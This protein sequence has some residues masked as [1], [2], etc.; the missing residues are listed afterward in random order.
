MS[1][2]AGI[3]RFNN[4]SALEEGLNMMK[5]IEQ[6]PSDHTGFWHDRSLFVGCAATWITP[7]SVGQPAPFYDEEHGLVITADA[8]I[9]NR[10]ELFNRLQIEPGKRKWMSDSELIGLAYLKW[11]T[12]AADY[13]IGDYAF[14]VWDS[15][16]Q[17]LFGARDP[18]GNRTLYYDHDEHKFS[19][20][21]AITP[22]LPAIGRF[23][24]LNQSWLAGFLAIPDLY[25][26]TDPASTPYQNISQLPSG[27]SFTVRNGRSHV[28]H[29]CSLLPSET[30]KFAS[31]GEVLEA[32]Q[33]VFQE[34]TA[35]RLRTFH[36][37]GATL[38][39][40]LDSSTVVSQAAG[41]LR[42]DN[43]ILYTYSYVPPDDFRDWTGKSRMAD[44]RP[45]IKATV[46]HVG[47]IKD[48]YLSLPGSSPL[49][50]IDSLLET[51]EVPYKNFENSFWIK[52]IYEHAA[53]DKI[54]ILLTGARGNYTISW[55]SV[56]DY[57]THLLRSF[58]YVRFY[59]ASKQFGKQMGIRRARLLPLLARNAYPFL[60][61]RSAPEPEFPSMI[62]AGFAH[63][64]GIMGKLQEERSGNSPAPGHMMLDRQ[65]YFGNPGIVGF[66]GGFGAKLSARYGLWERDVTADLRVIRFCLSLPVEQYIQQGV[67]RA[68]VRR[69]TAHL[70]PDQVRM[71]QHTRG[72]Q[73][74]DW[75]HRMLPTWG[76]FRRELEELS[77]DSMAAYFL[78][79]AK[80][81]EVLGRWPAAPEPERA[82]DLELR[83]LMRSLIAYRFLKTL[84]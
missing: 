9:D 21:T 36:K 56:T 14:V 29:G 62:S 20:C 12:G 15:A 74:V 19:F 71:N 68:L 2:I 6:Y 59:Q 38:S 54:G 49:S 25:E 23:K 16:K 61:R 40:G 1:V 11:G 50:E 43:K 8:I 58:H 35:A 75:L 13:L 64:S 30:M 33:A 57:C 22:L 51:L 45:Y 37:V 7:E 73:G 46:N 31:D 48:H 78:N 81:R 10:R 17:C 28:Q 80:I 67:G 53:R 69:A 34:A 55:G 52:G 84:Q 3:F 41:M 82:M 66:Q 5:A 65:M 4:D 27:H 83:F 47:N 44:E 79:T 26:S 77:S 70:L 32:F 42:A 24:V 39:G 72:V 60:D 63:N 18:L 76:A